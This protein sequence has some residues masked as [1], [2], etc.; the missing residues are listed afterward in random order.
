VKRLPERGNYDRALI[1]SVLDEALFCHVGLVSDG[2]PVVIPTIH[3]RA[4]DVL[5][6]HGSPA[7]RLL[8]TMG[9]GAQV[10][11]TVTLLDGLVLA[12][13][14]F[15]HSMNYRSVV[16]IGAARRVTDPDEKL[17]GLRAVVD[18]IGPGRWDEARRPSA[19]E[20]RKT[21]LIALPIDEVSAK[22]RSGP[23]G[24]DPEDL[25]LSVWAGVVPVV[26]SYGTPQP[27]AQLD[28]SIELP[29]TIAGWGSPARRLGS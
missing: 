22:V 1:N 9:T 24:D 14:V 23:V 18:H 21:E 5:Y 16:V 25:E 2:T 17:A 8:R 7:S 10:C 4:G 27:D 6:L 3:A 29:D 12:R 26:T 28:P 15:H 19:D 13:S 20:L 11:V